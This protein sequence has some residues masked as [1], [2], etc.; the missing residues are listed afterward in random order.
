MSHRSHYHSRQRSN[1]PCPDKPPLSNRAVLAVFLLCGIWTS[2]GEAEDDSLVP[3][4][5]NKPRAM[6]GGSS[7]RNNVFV[8]KTIPMD[9]DPGEY[10]RRSLSW[11]ETDDQ[12]NVKWVARLGS[13]TYGSP[14]AA[15]GRVFVG[16]NNGAAYIARYPRSVDLGCLLSF[17]ESDGAFQWQYSVTKHPGGR[18]HDWP[19]QGICSTPI[20]EGDRLWLVDNR[21]RVVCLDTE[22]FHDGEDDGPVKEEWLPVFAIPATLS[23]SI[24]RPLPAILQKEF[25]NHGIKIDPGSHWS[26]RGNTLRLMVRVDRKWVP[27]YLITVEKDKLVFSEGGDP[28]TAEPIF[29]LDN[30]LYPNLPKGKLDP[31]LI[32]FLN[33]HGI[34]VSA[35]TKLQQQGEEFSWEFVADN[36]PQRYRMTLDNGTIKALALVTSANTREADVVWR[37]DM[38]EELGVR[39]HNMANCS[40]VLY[41]DILFV[42][43]SNGVDESHIN[44]PA[45]K[46]PSFIALE[47]TTGKVLWQ[48]N[49]PSPRLMHGQ[50]GS[51]AVGVFEGVP[52]VIFPGGDGWVYAFRADT[53]D[54]EHQ[55]PILLWKFDA[56]PK[57]SKW[58]LGGRGTRNSILAF[59][60]ISDG[61]VYVTVGQD[62]E[63]GE[64]PGHLWCIDPTRRGDAS[65]ELV[66]VGKNGQPIP[67]ARQRIQAVDEKRGEH[68]KPNPNSAVVWHYARSKA[69][70]EQQLHRSLAS[71]V[72]Q[73]ELLILPDVAGFV[74]CLDA[75]T[76]KAH[77]TFDTFA[78][79]WS[80]PI[81]LNDKVLIGDEDGDVIVFPL[82][83]KAPQIKKN[84]WEVNLGSSVYATP[85]VSRNV[86]YIASKSHLFAIGAN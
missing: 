65:P 79:C 5:V 63:H 16:T 51:P 23:R 69:G 1:D 2:V 18:V 43:T 29:R 33:G 20:V 48:D 56:N 53:W 6:W 12:R 47:K 82:S 86:L 3:Q 68:T 73:K 30:E 80:T 40:P 19:G 10:D 84:L 17:R 14:V 71:P 28:Q 25:E 52:Q 41:G 9:W 24:G 21:G 15:A 39:Q 66:L 49:S 59:P 36:E 58:I 83:A 70:F 60:V 8:G 42:S 37:M 32:D 55:K 34:P 62:P 61:R 78:M 31:R 72:I 67:A 45:P 76:G 27:R 46:A 22:G 54:K 85:T 13:N 75:K 11:K 26:G 38:M 64:G 77:W 35:K 81:I 50:W 44:V 57:A 4:G 74:H 7:A